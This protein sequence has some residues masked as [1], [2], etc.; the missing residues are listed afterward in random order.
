MEPKEHLELWKYF[1]D[2][3]SSVKGAMFNTITWIIGFAA[4]ILA[5][6]FYNLAEF[7]DTN[8]VISL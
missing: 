4:G 3:A 8:G 7:D 5:F 2:R 6:V 1:N